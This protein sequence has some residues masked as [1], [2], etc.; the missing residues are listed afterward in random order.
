MTAREL[1]HKLLKDEIL[2]HTHL[3]LTLEDARA[4]IKEKSAER[5]SIRRERI[6]T[7]YEDFQES[8]K[9][10]AKTEQVLD[11][12]LLLIN[13]ELEKQKEED[14]EE[15]KLKA[16]QIRF[17]EKMLSRLDSNT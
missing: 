17:Y 9:L 14:E 5:K 4:F 3:G 13:N 10:K 11:K 15:K 16:L 7:I 6:D 1:T 12:A 2:L 8:K